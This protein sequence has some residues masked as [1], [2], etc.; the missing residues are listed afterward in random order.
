[1]H[2]AVPDG[3]ALMMTCRCGG[4]LKLDLTHIVEAERFGCLATAPL[5]WKCCLCARSRWLEQFTAPQSLAPEE[6][7][8]AR[9]L[10]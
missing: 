7:P 9:S 5:L 2:P 10:V 3:G 1:M 4:V 6:P 8:E